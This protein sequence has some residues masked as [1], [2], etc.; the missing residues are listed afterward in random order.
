MNKKKTPKRILLAEDD[1]SLSKLYQT[2][3]SMSGYEVIAVS[4]GK[5]CLAAASK[6]KIDVIL[7]DIIIPKIDGFAVLKKLKSKP[8]TKKIPVILLTN[9]GQEEDMKKGKELG[10]QGYLIKSNLTPAE[11]AKKI[12]EVLI[13]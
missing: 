5:E 10:A 12:E 4:D 1:P 7:L 3:L 13:T 8:K 2:K 6:G 9:L 11:V